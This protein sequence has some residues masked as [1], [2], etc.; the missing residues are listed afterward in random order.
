MPN[1]NR[2]DNPA[3]LEDDDST[4]TTTNKSDLTP[5]RAHYLKKALVQLQFAR[6]LDLISTEGPPNVSTLSYLGPPFTPPPKDTSPLDLPFLRYIFRQFVLTF[7]FMAAAPK[8]FYSLK[9]QPFVGA[10][11][12]RNISP[13]SVLDDADSEQ[14]TRK[15]LL[16]K[17]ER[18]LSLFVNAATKL[19][20]PEEVVRLTQADLDRLEILSRKR[21]KR[22]AKERDL[23]EVNI[24][25]VRTVIDKGR[26]R[27]RAH[28]EFIIRTR[29]SRYPDVYVS[30]RYGDFRTLAA[31]LAKKHPQEE[32]R[33]PPAKDK[34][35]S[36]A[37][38]I[39]PTTS[40]PPMSPLSRQSTSS[41]FND[42]NLNSPTGSHS[43][44]L[45]SNPSRLTREKN[46][47][48]L[49]SYLNT[50]MNSSTIA[51]SPVLRSFLLSG[52]TTMTSE[53][54]ED[55][56]RREEA[57]RVREEGRKKF[58]KEIAGRVEGLR[59]AVKSVKGDI[60]GKDGLT[61]IFATI[62]VTPDIRDLPSNYHAVVEW[63][64]ISLTSLASTVFQMFIASDD[65]SETFSGLKRIHG[66]M[67]YFMMKTA[68]KITNPVFWISFLLNH[69]EA[70]AYYNGKKES[71]PY[72][73]LSNIF[74]SRMFTSS[75]TEEVKALEEEIEAV[76]EKV[77]DPI[78]CE[79]VRQFV[80]APREI[81]TMFKNDA[82]A[83]QMHVLTIVLRSA[84]NPVL[85][86]AQMHRLARAHKAHIIYTK[87]RET[88]EDSDDDDG[89]QDED[90]WL[91]EDLK[92][93]AALYSKLKDREQL[94]ELIFE[95]FTSEL[96]KDII[97]IFYSPLAQVYRA[98][99]IADS[100]SDL[101]NFINDLIKTVEQVEGLSQDD[102]HLTV[103]AFINLIIRHEQSFYHFVHKVHSKGEGLFDNLMHWVELFLTAVR[104]GLGE[105]I[106]LEYLL[107]HKGQE[108]ADILFEVD[109]IAQYHYKLK[110]LYEDKLRRRFG[111][112]QSNEAD[113]EDE[114]TQ[115][116]VNGVVGEISFGDLVQGDAV[117]LAAEE[118]DEET[119]SD[120]DYSSSEYE[121]GSEDA[122][123]D[124]SEESRTDP[125]KPRLPPPLPSSPLSPSHSRISHPNDRQPRNHTRNNLPR[126]A[127]HKSAAGS[128]STLAY[129]SAP[130][131]PPEPK[132][133]RSLS[134][135]RAKSL[136]F[137]LGK[138][139]QDVP[140][141][142]SM[143][144]T[145]SV[146][147]VPPVPSVST[148]LRM[149]RPAPSRPL[150]PSP[151]SDGPPPPVPLK[152]LPLEKNQVPDSTPLNVPPKSVTVAPK[153]K[154]LTQGLKP[155]ELQ[156][157]PQLLPV[158]AEMMKPLLRLR[159]PQ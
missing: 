28:E 112:A 16:A 84:E 43:E 105:P 36:A 81:Q 17:V 151:D 119:S 87:H 2:P 138:R 50:L 153:K 19:V 143:P 15:K 69:S 6:E 146:P 78:M 77:D 13:T 68:L 79:K 150:P 96:L 156:H 66:L 65:A 127:M 21:Q 23:F 128:S 117:D 32:I 29:R 58:A 148:T 115:A 88:L 3:P 53:E 94:I 149:T 18:N 72:P 130:S 82:A 71:N 124:D 102:P 126:H 122:S 155:P 44:N 91:L 125:A 136:T 93:L 5:L 114:A 24:V 132:R 60:M 108:R 110:V 158:F 11:L 120:E 9:L 154:K 67:P 40:H 31:E 64:R 49:R 145:P 139:N 111:R 42:Y 73:T 75:L 27:S 14:A 100:L 37:P 157:I 109:K 59:E 90:A 118:T 104:E 1:T 55:A 70:E 133:K 54:L 30:R 56:K 97:T 10:V 142:P 47:L 159:Q 103:Q 83:E 33:L 22:L 51:S 63:A 113:A 26:M 41:T 135:H 48:T 7:P 134:L 95:G 8:D 12:A 116:L 140:P 152:D 98:A 39:T 61:H 92:V 20:E 46:R 80:Y 106:S 89:P 57:D 52:P 107:P 131:A 123:D 86:R 35:Y 25:S 38:S 34:T 137:S 141:V 121:T 62:K 76:K 147:P 101:Q 85:S 74:F 129:P 144:T 4:A 45:P 99:S